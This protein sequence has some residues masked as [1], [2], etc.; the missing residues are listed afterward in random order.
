MIGK[1]GS[2]ADVLSRI[3]VPGLY[4][5]SDQFVPNTVKID[6]YLSR[7]VI[8]HKLQQKFCI[9][10]PYKM[11]CTTRKVIKT[12]YRTFKQFFYSSNSFFSYCCLI[13]K[14]TQYFD[15]IN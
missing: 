3:V 4:A 15:C 7:D 13:V 5:Q 11:N 9:Q 2:V 14:I 10:P 8:L 1:L 6:D 12:T